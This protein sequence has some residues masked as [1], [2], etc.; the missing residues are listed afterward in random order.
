MK[1]ILLSLTLS[2][3]TLTIK[4]QLPPTYFSIESILQPTGTI[5]YSATGADSIL[6]T[7]EVS[8]KNNNTRSFMMDD[9]VSFSMKL[10]GDTIPSTHGGYWF[11]QFTSNLAPNDILTVSTNNWYAQA[12]TGNHE[13]CIELYFAISSGTEPHPFTNMDPNKEICQ[14][15]LFD[16]SLN[17]SEINAIP[18]I[19]NISVQNELMTVRVKNGSTNPTIHIINTLGQLVKTEYTQLNGQNFYSH[20]NVS[21]LPKG[22]YIVSISSEGGKSTAQKIYIP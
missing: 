10:D 16:F 14:T 12:T 4:A 1:T 18:Q 17:T 7:V 2:L 15:F 8:I 21:E 13:L 22:I 5:Y 20:I 11:H 19:S 6:T 3:F 9:Q